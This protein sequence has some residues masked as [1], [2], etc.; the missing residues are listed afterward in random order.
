MLHVSLNETELD[1][2]NV[3][4]SDTKSNDQL[5]TSSDTADP[6][7]TL[8]KSQS[9]VISRCDILLFFFSILKLVS[10]LSRQHLKA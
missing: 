8:T 4:E 5:D 2:G 7:F 6:I 1:S 3:E 10:L 9:S